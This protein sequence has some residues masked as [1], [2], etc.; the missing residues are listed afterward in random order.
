MDRDFPT[1]A[2]PSDLV[3]R[4]LGL[5]PGL[6]TG[7]GTN[8]YL[9]GRRD[10][11]LLDTGAG[12][13]GYVP[14]LARYLAGRGWRQPSRIVLTHR[15]RDHLGGVSQLRARFRGIPVAKMIHRDSGLPEAI[16]DLRDGQA[17][18]GDGATLIAVHT[19]GHASDH[20]CFY[21]VE[22]KALFTG[23]VVLGGSTTV[24][25]LDDGDLGDYMT[26]LRRLLDLDV[27]RIY[28]A[29]GPVIEDGPGRVREYI[30][31]RL[32]RERQILEA[33]GDGLVTIPEMVARIYADVSAALHQAAAQS[34]ASHLAKLAREGRVREHVVRD[35]PSR[36]ELV[37]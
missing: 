33:L 30:E 12:V 19:P 20:L 37:R 28:P 29:H 14:L 25:P 34:V 26:S 32:M 13:A 11:I 6:M 10:P 4:V 31:H 1:T 18:H 3:G 9:V 24:I 23:D 17:V 2:T 22:E 36:W 27:R 16:D 21:L 8:T 15:H 5:N 35:A 7:P